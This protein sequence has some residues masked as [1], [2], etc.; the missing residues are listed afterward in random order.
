[1]TP[2]QDLS[3][4][5]LKVLAIVAYK[6]PV[7]QSDIVKVIG[8]RT[9]DYVKTLTQK[10]LIKSIK[11]GRTKALVPTKEF[12]N[13]FGVENIEDL[14]SLF[15]EMNKNEERNEQPGFGVSDE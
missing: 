3:R 14:K 10:G 7:T 6:Q 8:N 15:K 2:Y 13:Y 5:L 1:M 9:Y 12:A 11:H 4:G